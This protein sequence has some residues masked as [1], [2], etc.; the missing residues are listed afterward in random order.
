MRFYLPY[1]SVII[2]IHH[3]WDRLSLCLEALKNQTYPKR[4]FEVIIINNAPSNKCPYQ[5]LAKNMKVIDEAK[6]GSYAARNKGIKVANGEVLAF[7]DSDCIPKFDW[8]EKAVSHMENMRIAGKVE[9]FF[10]KDKLTVA[11]DYEKLFAFN[12]KYYSSIGGG[13]TAN[14]VAKKCCFDAA[15][16]FDDN[17][18]SG[19]DIE[20]GKRAASSGIEIKYCPDVIVSHPAR[21]RLSEILIKKKRTAK[22]WVRSQELTAVDILIIMIKSVLPPIS[23]ISKVFNSTD[24]SAT[25]KFILIILVYYLKIYK[26]L[27]IFNFYY[28]YTNNENSKI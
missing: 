8:I 14:M 21:Y 28:T 4:K 6:R 1:V 9:L 5:R 2:P 11:E 26:S 7:T 13:V 16:L 12:Q 19:G 25:R 18:M 22:G 3:D 20:W 15:G 17:L 24:L 27:F 10:R 23:K